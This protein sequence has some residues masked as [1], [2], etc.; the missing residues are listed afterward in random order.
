MPSTKLFAFLAF[1]LLLTGCAP[2]ITKNFSDP[3]FNAASLKASNLVLVV[4]PEVS[5]EAYK[6]AYRHVYGASD[7]L[8]GHFSKVALDTLRRKKVNVTREKVSS[9][10]LNRLDSLPT[11]EE[12]ANLR[13]RLAAQDRKY[14]LRIRNIRISDATVGMLPD[15]SRSEKVL[16][17]YDA[18]VWD[19]TTMQKKESFTVS[20]K[21]AAVFGAHQAGLRAAVATGARYLVRYVVTGKS[22]F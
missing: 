13:E 10:L 2:K 11:A 3:G 6:D 16:L 15:G 19:L 14:L 1:S 7:S 22:E 21:G 12:V 4:S 9:E 18:D 20:A 5:V 8:A 17:L